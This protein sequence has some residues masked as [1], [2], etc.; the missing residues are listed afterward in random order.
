MAA[1]MTY[2]PCC[3]CHQ[4]VSGCDICLVNNVKLGAK[5]VGMF[6]TGYHLPS[7]HSDWQ[8]PVI[9]QALA[10]PDLHSKIHPNMCAASCM[11][12][13]GLPGRLDS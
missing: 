3:C 10:L 7:T 2:L 12:S 8:P 1:S 11:P 6:M 9:G 13:R 5:S 4:P